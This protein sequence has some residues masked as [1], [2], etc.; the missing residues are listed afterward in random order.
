MPNDII[1]LH[2]LKG[3]ELPRGLAPD[4][5]S[6]FNDIIDHC[7]IFEPQERPMFREILLMIIKGERSLTH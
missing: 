2:V 6:F 1:R 3:G 5:P 7:V 4:V